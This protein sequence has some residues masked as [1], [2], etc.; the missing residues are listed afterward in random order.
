MY[1]KELKGRPKSSKGLKRGDRHFYEAKRE[2]YILGD[3]NI[4]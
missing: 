1:C 4:Y 2:A 3:V